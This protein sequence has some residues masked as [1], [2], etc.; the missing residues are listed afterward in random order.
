MTIKQF[1][2]LCGCNPQTLRYYDH[3][4]LLKP[5]RVDRW[6][7]YRDYDEDQ[8]LVF[9]K[10]KNLQAA[11]LAIDEIRKLL[12]QDQYAVCSALDAK[13]AEQ[14][15]RLQRI[16]AIRQSFLVEMSEIQRRIQ[17][18]KESILQAMER[19]DPTEEFGIG[20]EYA[21]L[22]R[23]A[24]KKEGDSMAFANTLLGVLLTRNPEKQKSLSC[25]TALSVDGRNR[26][27]MLKRRM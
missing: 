13:I 7:G 8:A 9:V 4:E 27:W 3:V 14:E 17:T 20:A 1:A 12:D 16:K 6:S 26:F 23:L 10:N 19:Y 22:V 15:N 5:V 25:N 24:R 11:G 18:A 21:L 2:Q